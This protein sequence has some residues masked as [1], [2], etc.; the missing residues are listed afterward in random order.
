M[1]VK[2]ST[3]VRRSRGNKGKEESMEKS[4][5]C[6]EENKVSMIECHRVELR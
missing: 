6:K 2:T 4:G 3:N 5:D 1:K